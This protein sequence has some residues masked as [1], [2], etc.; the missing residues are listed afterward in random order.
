MEHLTEY[1][2]NQILNGNAILFLG[3]GASLESQSEDGKYKGMTGNQLKDL[4]CDEF[5]SGKSKNKSLSYVD[6][7][8]KDLA[9]TGP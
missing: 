5:L 1:L 4:I 3:A 7:V 2:L 6:A 8:T 9:S